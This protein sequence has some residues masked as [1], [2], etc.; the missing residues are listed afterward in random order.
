ML[1]LVVVTINV[2]T[3]GGLIAKA[4]KA[5]DETKKAADLEEK[6]IEIITLEADGIENGYIVELADEC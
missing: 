3:D 5:A 4:K 2:A 6:Q 1:I